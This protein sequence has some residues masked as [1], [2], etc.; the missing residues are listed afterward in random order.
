MKKF[1]F[2]FTIV[3]TLATQT[4]CQIDSLMNADPIS[5]CEHIDYEFDPPQIVSNDEDELFDGYRRLYFIHGLGGNASSW[6]NTADACWNEEL[7]IPGFL[8]RKSFVSRLDYTHSTNGNLS[9]AANQIRELIRNQAQQDISNYDLDPTKAIII[10]HS[11][12]GVVGRTI[13]HLDAKRNQIFPYFGVGYGGFINVAGPLQGAQ[14]L[15]NRHQIQEFA[16]DACRSLSKGPAQDVPIIG[17]VLKFL[18]KRYNITNN[19]CNVISNNILPV[20]FSDYYASI[21]NDYQVGAPFISV[22][23]MDSVYDKYRSIPKISAYAVEEQDNILWRTANW[24]V[25]DPNDAGYFE[26]NDDWGFYNST[27]YPNYL[28]YQFMFNLYKIKYE[29]CKEKLT[30]GLALFVPG[31]YWYYAIKADQHRTQMENWREGVEWFDSANSCWLNIIG[32]LDVSI[33]PRDSNY[34]WSQ[35]GFTQ[36]E[37]TSIT[38]YCDFPIFPFGPSYTIRIEQKLN[39]GIVLAE[40]AADLTC[41]THTPIKVFTPKGI[42]GNSCGSSHMQVRNDR[43]LKDFLNSTFNGEYGAFF[44]TSPK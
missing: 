42:Y 37:L 3:C 23:N 21:T 34:N 2:L 33:I 8:A 40:S 26:A 20:F 24:L 39:D 38:S 18:D 29:Y 16:E 36:S 25:N 32:A 22:L 13:L 28:N 7:N 35:Y 41:A 1:M 15:N 12:G 9:T 4:Y 17:K 27:I 44:Y 14:I 19:V 31:A 43:G 11:Q 5:S 10:G 30:W 6:T